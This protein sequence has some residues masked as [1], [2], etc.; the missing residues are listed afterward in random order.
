MAAPEGDQFLVGIDALA[1]LGGEG[2]GDGDGLDIT[3]DGDQQGGCRDREPEAGIEGRQ[4]R[5]GQ[6]LG[7]LADDAHAALG[8]AEDPGD[9]DGDDDG[10][11]GADLGEDV[12]AAVL[13]AGAFQ[14][15]LEVAPDPEQE[16]EGREAD[17]GGPGVDLAEID[18]EFA[19]Q[20]DEIVAL[21]GDAEDVLELARGD[22]DARGGDEA[23]DHRMAE[24]VG[25]EAEAQEAHGEQHQAREH[26][27]RYGG[28]EIFRGALLGQVADGGGGHEADHG[29]RADGEGARGAEDR[30]EH[31]RGDRGVEADL[32][33]QAGEQGIGQR[34]RDQHDR[35]DGRGDQIVRQ[36]RA[37][38]LGAPAQDRKILSQHRWPPRPAAQRCA[39][40]QRFWHRAPERQ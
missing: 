35:D 1:A 12:G 4:G 2:L 23:R 15:G 25:E 31:E 3:D 19:E 16:A 29:D 38:V 37:I 27:E 18:R 8:E 14:G 7:D 32:G 9:G 22:Q 21:G 10:G 40:I 17:G 33:G 6:A 28:A 36:G 39:S 30:V 11:D 26:G 34:L 13:Q 20:V 24:E 5:A